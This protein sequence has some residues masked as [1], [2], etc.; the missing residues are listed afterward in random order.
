MSVTKTTAGTSPLIAA[1]GALLSQRC[2]RL[3]RAARRCA[4]ALDEP[5]AV[6]QVRVATRRMDAALSLFAPLLS[7][8]RTRKLC[9]RLR[10]LRRAARPV[11]DCDVLLQRLS[12]GPPPKSPAV[13][14]DHDDQPPTVADPDVA[15]VVAALAGQ[16]ARAADALTPELDRCSRKWLRQRVRRLRRSA[17]WRSSEQEPGFAEAISLLAA[18]ALTAF[19]AS[20]ECDLSDANALHRFRLAGKRL[21]YTLEV[22]HDATQSGEATALEERLK[23]WQQQLGA[24]NDHATAA[25]LLADLAERT[26]DAAVRLAI[27]Q[28]A[29]AERS[30][31]EGGAR[32]FAL[33]WNASGREEAARAIDQYRSGSGPR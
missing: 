8:R 13:S 15:G 3:R 12:P 14:D 25:D 16:R 17:R 19:A 9:K 6:H 28:M 21:R 30:C 11:R 29:R 5:E 10:G 1:A 18:P 20:G 23:G 27:E 2:R 32:T 4:S 24:I 33:W 31:L 22:L 26:D 7:P